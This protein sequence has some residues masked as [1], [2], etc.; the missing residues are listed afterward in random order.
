[1]LFPNF[2]FPLE[3]RG[4]VPKFLIAVKSVFTFQDSFIQI[5]Y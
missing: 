2:F 3:S 4:F 1:M 5:F